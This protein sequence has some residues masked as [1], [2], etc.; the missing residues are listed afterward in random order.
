MEVCFGMPEVVLLTE[1]TKTQIK[2]R[3]SDPVS[4]LIEAGAIKKFAEAIGDNNPAFCNEILAQR[5][6]HREIIAPPTFLRSLKSEMVSLH[7]LNS[8]TRIL[9]RGSEWTYLEPVKIGDT[10]TTVNQIVNISQ[11]RLNV[12]LAVLLVIESKYTNQSGKIAATQRSTII[13]Y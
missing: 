2:S 3:R 10:V 9:D 4:T 7:E 6:R 11:L 1:E 8:L 5:T 12:G 13:C